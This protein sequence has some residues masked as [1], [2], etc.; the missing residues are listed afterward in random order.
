MSP[1]VLLMIPHLKEVLWGGARLQQEWGKDA[2]A[3][4]RIGESW[5]VSAVPGHE[6]RVAG[7]GSGLGEL[8]RRQPARFL[9]PGATADIFP[10]LVKLICTTDLLSV[11]VHP[12]DAQAFRL[13][14]QPRG[15]HEAWLV[16]DAEPGAYLYLG[17]REGVGRPELEHAL[18]SG[19]PAALR[20]LLRRVSVRPG[21]VYDLAPGTLHAIG[22]GLV[23]LEVQQP[24]DLTYRV[25]DWNRKGPDGRPRELHVEKALSVLAPA[26]R[27]SACAPLGA[28]TILPGERLLD[29]PDFRLE[30]WSV[31]GGSWLTVRELVA[32]TCL[33]GTGSMHAAGGAEIALRKG[34]SCVVPHSATMVRVTGRGLILAAAMPP[35]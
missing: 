13:E 20:D 9:G 32:V 29:H 30:R 31:D 4:A 21:E 25:H 18:A 7:E 8:F 23:L 15:K 14:G 35:R 28:S 10:F 6:S 5:E 33:A 24:S 2:P 12:D 27:P 16:L 26:N 11:Q 22:P 17:L 19:E 3:D 34:L 1:G